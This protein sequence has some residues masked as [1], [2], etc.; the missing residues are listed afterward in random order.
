[1][2]SEGDAG[3]AID[4]KGEVPGGGLVAIGGEI[5]VFD[6]GRLSELGIDCRE[7]AL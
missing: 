4:I 2:S 5:D 3:A 6:P 7:V 1:M